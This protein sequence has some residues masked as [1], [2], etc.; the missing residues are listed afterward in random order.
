METDFILRCSE[1]RFPG[2]CRGEKE[3]ALFILNA[4]GLTFARRGLDRGKIAE[5]LACGCYHAAGCMTDYELSNT[6]M[7]RVA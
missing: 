4:N 2:A 3:F 7:K 6:C 5:K 1:E